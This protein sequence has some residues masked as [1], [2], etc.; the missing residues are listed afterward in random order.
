VSCH[1]IQR[2]GWNVDISNWLIIFLLLG[3]WNSAWTLTTPPIHYCACLIELREQ[4]PLGERFSNWTWNSRVNVGRGMREKFYVTM[5]CNCYYWTQGKKI[6]LLWVSIVPIKSWA[7]FHR[8]GRS[9]RKLNRISQNHE[10]T[11]Y[12][13]EQNFRRYQVPIAGQSHI[14]LGFVSW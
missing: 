4:S 2:R 14:G 12:K 11:V 5:R 7:D 10:I 3:G 1:C 6:D 9:S 13:V 8:S